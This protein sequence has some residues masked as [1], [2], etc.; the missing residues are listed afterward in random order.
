MK[1]VKIVLVLLIIS[2]ALPIHAFA[3]ETN[4]D[5]LSKPGILPGNIL[6]P[7]DT[8]AENVRLFFTFNPMKKANL[9]NEIASER[10]AE[11]QALVEKDKI[12]LAE[13]T[14][15]V[16]EDCLQQISE[17]ISK[18]IVKG[19]PV[20]DTVNTIYEQLQKQA[21]VIEDIQSSLSSEQ[22]K[23]AQEK[24]TEMETIKNVQELFASQDKETLEPILASLEENNGEEGLVMDEDM[25]SAFSVLATN[26]GMTTED[27]F[28]SFL[29]Q[30]PMFQNMY[31]DV[32]TSSFPSFGDMFHRVWGFVE[33]MWDITLGFDYE[34]VQN[35]VNSIFDEVYRS[36]EEME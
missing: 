10:L 16:Y 24:M 7:L 19:E 28:A 23:K 27:V 20:G 30:N 11:S 2:L 29:Q 32:D 31:R 13:D 4:A 18:N 12:E 22:V 25:S 3:S 1:R 9:L 33:S 14:L 34:E 6:Y 35:T 36:I 26:A 5:S 21:Q 15:V 8:W 17:I